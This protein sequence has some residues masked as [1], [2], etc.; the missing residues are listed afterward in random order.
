MEKTPFYI[1]TPIYYVNDKPHIGHAYTTIVADVL[2]RFHRLMGHPSY[3][4]TGTDEHGQ[5]VQQTAEK[6]G[7]SPINHADEM[8][9]RFQDAWSQLNISNDD[10][11]RT[12]EPRHTVVVQKILK[13]LHD[14]G[15][16]YSDEYDGWYDASEE[17]F[18]PERDAPGGIDPKTGKQLERITEKNYFFKMGSYQTWLIEY[19]EANPDFIQPSY[20]RNETLGFLKNNELKDLCISRPKS[21][22][23]WGIELPFDS[24]YVTYVWFDA[25]VN[26]IS[27]VGYLSEDP[28]EQKKFADTWPASYHL[29]GKD[30]LTTHTVYWPTMLKAMGVAQPKTIFAHGWW[31]L[32]ESEDGEDEKMS[33]SK[34]NVVDPL[35]YVDSYGV[36]AVRYFLAAE[37]SLGQDASFTDELFNKRYH[38]DLAKGIGNASSRVLALLEKN[39]D[40]RIPE[41]PADLWEQAEETVLW[42]SLQDAIDALQ[43]SIPDMKLH[44]GIASVIAAVSA[45]DR[46]LELKKPW[47]QAKEDDKEPLACTLTAGAEALYLISALLSPVMPAKMEQ[48]Q[49]ALGQGDASPDLDALRQPGLIKP[50][51][52]TSKTTLFPRVESKKKPEPPADKPAKKGTPSKPTKQASE[53]PAGVADMN[54]IAFDDFTKVQLKTGKI[55]DAERIEGTDKLMKIQVLIGEERRQI[56]S[57]IA[58]FYEAEDLLHKTVVVVTNLKPVKLRGVESNGM[59]L[60]ATKGEALRLVTVDGEL[61]SGAVVR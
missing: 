15:E 4:L 27:G 12:T 31:M 32:K 46:Y 45:L 6:R 37:M 14:K 44:Q 2:T 39:F 36:D 42:Q 51:T 28:A 41:V 5:K 30:I 53:L 13:E 7:K 22:M 34:G 9:V 1:T 8:V 35:D 23:S 40:G 11:I 49:A 54:F 18:V 55:C 3:F 38:A 59:L 43:T 52:Q 20:R 26:Y 16:I 58:P 48:L 10:F 61:A 60:A 24:E 50:G 25:L 17:L 56:V 19:I 57:G 21:R 29:I 47:N 33:K